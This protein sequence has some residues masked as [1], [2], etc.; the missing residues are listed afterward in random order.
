VFAVVENTNLPSIMLLTAV[1]GTAL[2][3][4]VS[5]QGLIVSPD[6]AL[7]AVVVSELAYTLTV[8]PDSP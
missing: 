4:R 6:I 3:T 8:T 5:I 2:S 7:V 1:V